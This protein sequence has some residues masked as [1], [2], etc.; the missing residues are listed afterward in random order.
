MD[1]LGLIPYG[2]K[3]GGL[4]FTASQILLGTRACILRDS[5][6]VLHSSF[7]RISFV[8]AIPSNM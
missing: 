2:G 1:H 5:A 7:E 4:P 6:E 3:M 8:S